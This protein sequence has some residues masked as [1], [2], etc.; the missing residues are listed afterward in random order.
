MLVLIGV[1][2][3]EIFYAPVEQLQSPSHSDRCAENDDDDALLTVDATI[4]LGSRMT[5]LE[6]LL[7][8]RFRR[9]FFA[10]AFHDHSQPPTWL[11]VNNCC[12]ISDGHMHVEHIRRILQCRRLVKTMC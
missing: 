11:F 6:K 5:M 12:P 4:G 10:S 2:G 9:R 8:K 1:A 3:V 7:A